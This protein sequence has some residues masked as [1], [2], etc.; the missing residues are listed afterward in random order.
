MGCFSMTYPTP[1]PEALEQLRKH[2]PHIKSRRAYKRWKGVCLVLI[3][4]KSLECASLELNLHPRT[5]QK[6]QYRYR[7]EGLAC[8]EDRPMGSRG[9]RLVSPEAESAFF[10]SYQ[11]KAKEGQIFRAS[12]LHKDYVAL[13]GRDCSLMTVYRGLKRNGWSKKMPRPRHP[14]GDEAA[15]TLFKKTL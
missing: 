14:Q 11:E 15:Q 1:S 10:A 4:G 2:E 13:I 6:H 9:S 5:L 7:Q 3:E 8:F 12:D